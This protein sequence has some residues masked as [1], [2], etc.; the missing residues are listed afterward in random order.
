MEFVFLITE[1]E[2]VP[3]L[4]VPPPPLPEEEV[5]PFIV[6]PL[7]SFRSLSMTTRRVFSSDIFVARTTMICV[8]ISFFFLVIVTGAIYSQTTFVINKATNERYVYFYCRGRRKWDLVTQG[9]PSWLR[10]FRRSNGLHSFKVYGF[11]FAS[12]GP[13]NYESN[14][15]NFCGCSIAGLFRFLLLFVLIPSSNLCEHLILIL[16]GLGGKASCHIYWALGSRRSLF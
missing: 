11:G 4:R 8:I 14:L 6:V 10:P 2:E 9:Q 5:E 3:K 12:L 1:E 7:L 15:S 13:R 16:E